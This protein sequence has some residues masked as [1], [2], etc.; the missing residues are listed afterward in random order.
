VKLPIRIYAEPQ[1]RHQGQLPPHAI[2]PETACWLFDPASLT[3]R[4]IAA[5]DRQFRVE[6]IAQRWEVPYENEARRLRIRRKRLALIRQVFLYCEETPWVYART[7]IPRRTLRG[8]EKFLARLGDKPLGAVLFADPSMRR[9]PLEVAQLMPGQRLYQQATARL[10]EV[11]TS[12]WGRRS[13]FYLRNKPLLVNEV[14]LPSI[15]QCPQASSS[16]V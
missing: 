6:V 5:C 10:P 2:A 7:V 12:I 16:I 4:V 8:R 9:D 1:W 14:F 3:A 15:G 11:A 13:V